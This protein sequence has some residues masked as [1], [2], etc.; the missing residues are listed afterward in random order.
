[1]KEFLNKILFYIKKRPVR[2]KDVLI[3][4]LIILLLLALCRCNK[5][6]TKDQK[7]EDAV[8]DICKFPKQN[9]KDLTAL[10]S[11]GDLCSEAWFEDVDDFI[12]RL[13]VQNKALKKN[14]SKQAEALYKK[15]AELVK[16]LKAF[17]K[18][19]SKKTIDALEKAFKAYQKQAKKGC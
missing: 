7:I 5:E 2:V 13:E 6:K 18:D 17:R 19:Q 10:L 16:C 15:Q 4:I 1:M 8:S 3:I 9:A 14:H 11:S 12:E